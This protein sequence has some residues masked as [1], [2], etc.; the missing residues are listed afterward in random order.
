MQIKP[1]ISENSYYKYGFAVKKYLL[2]VDTMLHHCE[3]R[4]HKLRGC[5]GRRAVYADDG[6]SWMVVAADRGLWLI[7]NK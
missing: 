3:Q 2:T 1:N 7:N 4:S 5:D 6:G